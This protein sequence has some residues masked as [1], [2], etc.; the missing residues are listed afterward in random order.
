M[1]KYGKEDNLYQEA[2]YRSLLTYLLAEGTGT[3]G[4]VGTSTSRFLPVLHSTGSKRHHAL[5]PIF[6]RSFYTICEIENKLQNWPIV[7]LQASY[8]KY[9]SDY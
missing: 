2:T 5:C 1:S 8:N 4:T 7:F 3:F 6:S 9:Q